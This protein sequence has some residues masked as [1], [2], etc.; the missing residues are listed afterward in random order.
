[1]I[2]G[3]GKEEEKFFHISTLLINVCLRINHLF[4]GVYNPSYSQKTQLKLKNTN[5]S[6]HQENHKNVWISIYF[7]YNSK[8]FESFYYCCKP[9]Q[10]HDPLMPAMLHGNRRK[11]GWSSFTAFCRFRCLSEALYSSSCMETINPLCLSV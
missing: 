9:K 2:S 3:G 4:L 1:M 11:K 5:L 6:D 8:P 7:L 10:L